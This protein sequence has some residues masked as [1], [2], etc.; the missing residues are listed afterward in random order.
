VRVA[1][2]CPFLVSL[3]LGVVAPGLAHRLP[4]ATAARVLAA[5]SVVAAAAR[6]AALGFLA[7]TALGQLPALASAGH[8]S[9]GRLAATT[10]VP[11]AVALAAVVAVAA[12][13]V[14]GLRVLAV[15]VLAV[16]AVRALGR[17]LPGS[18]QLV[19]VDDDIEA[20]AVPAGRGRIV[21]SRAHLADL[22][23]DERRA[24]LLHESAHLTHRHHLYRLA[25]DLAGAVDLLQRGVRPAVLY[26]TERWAD[27]DA[28]GAV[29]DRAVVA[30][31]LARS[32]LR[33]AGAPRAAWAPLAMGRSGSPLVPRVRALLGPAPRQR[34]GLL[35]ATAAL[36]LVAVASVVHAHEDAEAVFAGAAAAPHGP[37]GL[38]LHT[39]G[40]GPHR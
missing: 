12:G 11:R 8:W 27:E 15:R 22:P 37:A 5:S 29:G 9:A 34:P 40:H 21:A 38:H 33:T 26:A 19:V 3:L 30:R 13:A 39:G 18:G 4:P 35:L 32:G 7:S 36:A 2:Y 31:V 6:C 24:L 16:R 14:N 20:V 23:A 17:S 10:P 28:A 1:V 25:V